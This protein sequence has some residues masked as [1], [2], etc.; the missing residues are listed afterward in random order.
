MTT[1][2][3]H[4]TSGVD[5]SISSPDRK[6][7]EKSRLDYCIRL[8]EAEIAQ[9]ERIEKKAQFYLSFSAI[10]LGAIFLKQDFLSEL[11]KK[12]GYQYPD[13]IL[14][15]ATYIFLSLL[16]MFMF[17]SL[18]A[19]S[20][21]IFIRT[22]KKGY[23]DALVTSLFSPSTKHFQRENEPSFLESSAKEYAIAVEINN[24]NNI[25]KGKWLQ[26]A[27]YGFLGVLLALSGL[28]V[29]IIILSLK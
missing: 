12:F 8:F 25:R 3:G 18:I 21:T 19:I 1:H 4:T 14:T 16:A 23:P 27:S 29:C 7:F 17:L 9:K 28:I 24:K 2:D 5:S 6:S 15:T 10:L 26:L 13:V 11:A 20:G 22:F